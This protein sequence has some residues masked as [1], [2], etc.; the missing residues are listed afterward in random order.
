MAQI[1]GKRLRDLGN[2]LNM[3]EMAQRLP[4][5]LKYL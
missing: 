3:W 2:G 1:C 4:K 5:W